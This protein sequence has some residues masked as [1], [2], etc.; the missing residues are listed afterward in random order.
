[1]SKVENVIRSS[2]QVLLKSNPKISL[3]R[4]AVIKKDVMRGSGTIV[5][6][7]DNQSQPEK[8]ISASCFK[9]KVDRISLMLSF[10]EYR[11]PGIAEVIPKN[12]S[13]ISHSVDEFALQS[14]AVL[15]IG[16][17]PA[18]ENVYDKV[19][20]FVKGRP[21]D[22]TAIKATFGPTDKILVFVSFSGNLKY[23]YTGV[24]LSSIKMEDL[25]QAFHEI[26]LQASKFYNKFKPNACLTTLLPFSSSFLARHYDNRGETPQDVT[27]VNIIFLT[28]DNALF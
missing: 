18:V 10:S 25:S 8:V 22:D 15:R 19:L 3:V 17:M 26:F 28:G 21:R 2:C 9:D 20:N 14:G 11:P 23:H 24:N 4:H 7:F 5:V 13:E 1:M 27:I 12:A 6:T 16:K